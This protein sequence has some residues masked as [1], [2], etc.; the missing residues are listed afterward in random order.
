M[1][2]VIAA[3]RFLAPTS[4]HRLDDLACELLRRMFNTRHVRVAWCTRFVI[5]ICNVQ[6]TRSASAGYTHG[7]GCLY[8]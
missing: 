5:P 6:P 2:G 7:P 3:L 8:A 4:H 1:Q